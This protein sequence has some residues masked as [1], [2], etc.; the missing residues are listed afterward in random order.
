MGIGYDVFGNVAMIKFDRSVS[1]K[2]KK[3][4]A[5]EFLKNHRNITTVLEKVGGFSGRLR[6]QKT[7][8]LAGDKTK[9]ALYRENG[10]VFRLNVDTCYF[11]PRLSEERKE[12]AK[13]VKKNEDV[14][15]MFGGVAPFAI[16]IAKNSK[17]GKVVSVEISRECSKYA[18]TNVKR[19][20]LDNV[21]I[22]QGD[23]RKVVGKGK[24]VDEKFDRIVMARPNLKDSFLDVAFQVVRKNGFIHYYGFY[25]DDKVDEMKEMIK[26][27]AVKAKKKIKI[28]KV[29]KAGDVG[30]R[31]FRFRVDFKV[32]N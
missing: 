31:K 19:N 29:K 5:C 13:V 21:E 2:D 30:V 24:K 3:K 26:E 9:E 8:W 7:K 20:K 16:V 27:E 23:V 28:L 14:L 1:A 10:C 18:L 4:F 22:V 12:M 25:E 15:V 6:T 32:L 17:A 11:S